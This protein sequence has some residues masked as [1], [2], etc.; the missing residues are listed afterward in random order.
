MKHFYLIFLLLLTSF[1]VLA[2]DIFKG[3]IIAD[4]IGET[5][6]NIV[7]LNQKTGVVNNN[8]GQFSIAAKVGDSLVF[9]SVQYEPYAIQ[10]KAGQLDKMNYIYLYTIVNKLEEVQLSNI[11]LSGDLTQ[12]TK[13]IETYVFDPSKFGLPVSTGKVRTIEEKRL[14]TAQTGGAIGVLIDVI[15]GRMAMLKRQ[16]E[17]QKLEN[18][19]RKARQ[20]LGDNFFTESLALPHEKID[21]FLYFLENTDATFVHKTKNLNNLEWIDYLKSKLTAFHNFTE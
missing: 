1:S 6:V 21:D 9:S 7:N 20:K 5:Q 15:S 13:K 18:L 12:D 8:K 3:Y 16:V 17:Y 11:S 2:Q 14:Y 4:S 10:I 19:I